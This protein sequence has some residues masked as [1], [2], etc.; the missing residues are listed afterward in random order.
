MLH[1]NSYRQAIYSWLPLYILCN[2]IVWL[3]VLVCVFVCFPVYWEQSLL[4][5]NSHALLLFTVALKGLPFTWL[6]HVHAPHQRTYLTNSRMQAEV[7]SVWRE[8]ENIYACIWQI[9][10]S[11]W[12][13]L[14]VSEHNLY[15]PHIMI[16]LSSH[17][18]QP[19]W[20]K[21][22]SLRNILPS[23]MLVFAPRLGNYTTSSLPLEISKYS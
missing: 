15:T 13:L 10:P 20:K 18:L 17:H 23:L 22:G 21:R 11:L 19:F 4:A 3:C 12:W 7:C 8:E 16:K 2:N 6:M 14:E 9:K 5:D 1:L